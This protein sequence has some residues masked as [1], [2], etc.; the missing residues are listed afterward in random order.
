M[1][2]TNEPM[3]PSTG[4]KDATAASG[5]KP[6][7][8]TK[9]D[10]TLPAKSDMKKVEAHS[11]NDKSSVKQKI[12]V[13]SSIN[14]KRTVINSN[15]TSVCKTYNKCLM[16]VKKP[17]VNKPTRRKFT[18]G[19]QY[20]LTR[21]TESKV[22]PAKQT[23]SVLQI[24]LSYLNSSCSKHMTGDRSRIRNFMK[25]FIR[26]VRFKND[27]FGAIMGYG[28]YVI[29]D[30]VISRVYY[31]EGLGHN[32]FS[33]GQFCDSDLE[34]DETP[35]FVIKFLKQIQVG[36]NKTVR[37]IRT[38]IGTEFVNQV[39]TEYYESVSIFHQKSVPRTPQ[40]IGIIERWNYTLVE[41]ARTML[42]F[43]T[44]L[45]FLWVEAV[46]TACYT[47]NR[48]LIHTRHNKT[49][50]ELV[51]DKKPD[52][53]FLYVFGALCYPT[54]DSEDLG[55][56]RPTAD[57][58]IFIGYA[59]NRKGY[60]IYNKRTQRIM[61][62]IHMQFDKLTEPMAPVH[63]STRPEPILLTPRQ[64]SVERPVPPA[65]AVQV[66]IA[67][68]GT[69]S[70][71]IIDQDAP[72]T[73]YSPSSSV[74]QPPIS[75]QGVAARPTIEDNPFAQ[76]DNDPFVNVFA[77]E[78]SY[79]E[80]SSGD[81][82]SAEST[83]V[84][85]PHNHLRKWSKD[86][87]LDNELVP[88]PGCVMIIALKWIY[89][90]KLDEYGDV[91]KNKAWYHAKPTKKDLEAIKL[92][93]HKEK[94]V[95]KCLVSWR[96]LVSWSSKKQKSTAISTTEVE[97][98]AMSGCYAQILWMR[99]R[100]TDY[101]SEENLPAPTRSDEQLVPV[102]AH[103]PY[104]KSNL[105]LNLQKLQKN[106]IFR[107]YVDILQNTNFFRAFSA[108]A[109][110]PS[111]YI[112]HYDLLCDALEITLVDPANPFVSPPAGEIVM[113]FMNELGYPKVI[114]FVSHMHVNNLFQP[115]REILSLINQ[116][117]T[118]K[119]SR[120]DKPR[121]HVL[122][123]LWGIMTR[124]NVD[125]AELLWEEFV[126][127]IQTFFTHRDS[128]KIPS[129]KPTPHVIPYCRFTKLIIYYLG[130]KYNIHRRP[131]SP[132][133]VTGD[134]FLPGN[135]KFVPKGKKDEVFGMPIPKELITEA[136]Q[137]S[138]YYMQYVEMAARKVEAKEGGKKK[139][140][141][142]A[143]KPVKPAPTKQPKPKPI[144]ENS[145]KPTRVQ[146][147]GKGKV[148]KV[149]K[150]K[151]PLK[152]I[153]EEEHAEREPEPEP[154]GECEE[155][156][157]ERAIQMS[158][159]S[160]EAPGQAH[161][162]GVDIPEPIAE[163]T[164]QLLVVEGKGK[165]IATDEQ[166]AQSLL[167]LHKPKKTIF[168]TSSP[169]NAETDV[170]NKVNLEEKTAEIN[171][172][173][174]GSDP[175]KTPKSRPPTEHVLMEEDKAGPDPGQSH[176]DFARPEPEPMHDDFIATMYPQVHESL[177]L[178]DEEHAQEQDKANM[179]T[180]VESMVTVLVQQASSSVSLLST[181]VIDLTPLKPVSSTIQE[182]VFTT[183]TTTTTTLPLPPPPQ[184]QSITDFLLA[185]R[186]LTLE[187]RSLE[188][189]MEL[190]NRDEFLAEKDKSRKRRHDDKDPPPP[191]PDLDLS[192]KKRHESDASGSKQPLAPQSSAWKTSNTREAPSSSSKQK[193]VHHS[194][195]PAEDVPI[196]DDVNISDSED[197]DTAHLLK[198]KTRPD[199]LKPVPEE[200][201]P[202]T[203]EPD[204]I[205]PPN[206][207]PETENNWA[208]VLT[209]SYQ[210]PDEYKL[211]WQTGD[212][213][214]FINWFCKRI[215]KKKLSKADLEGPTLKV[216]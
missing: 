57:I 215:G 99:S 173:Q 111:I 160:F 179:E 114:H 40:Q 47:Q 141:P 153:N 71:T 29:G 66:P 182:Q 33:V 36:L 116:C 132:R 115:W 55:K 65:P 2:K 3:I 80:S 69:P 41:A 125:Y 51:H 156:D 78:P 172:G 70:S 163:T 126:Q 130:S 193:F 203:P 21:F 12:C 15:C 26:T 25:K 1:K 212:M 139:T 185:Y 85:H 210:D 24:V 68:A 140:A 77:P 13:D 82:S 38:D 9:K 108:S 169:T 166:A 122:Q 131:E 150:G 10:R 118:G 142:K 90:V 147:V 133:H 161:V 67:S 207:L 143:D 19:E 170:E 98:I 39:L 83:Q 4:I 206:D 197:I 76:A 101:M 109:N 187:Q 138:E 199:W 96:Q 20:P 121:H 205:I 45:M 49:P 60:R 95:W 74:I 208:N 211:L 94:Y 146:K 149:L 59:P 113:D 148:Q 16:F 100:L 64:I 86:H 181:P 56:L 42:I 202:E 8:N 58:G 162:G 102:K 194:K 92:S 154:Q 201:R 73:S 7:S 44:A 72:S 81:V 53:K 136:I 117:L 120:N 191:L 63:I 168:D 37:Y 54:N 50:Y 6:R 158:M 91:L 152:L 171:E 75:H 48:S 214:S 107:I 175:G 112:Q 88:K 61:E 159:E 180:K 28:D 17:P 195:Q 145:T 167:D 200:D 213:S 204:W 196:P 190:A 134:D 184:Q 11:R 216:V 164:R 52:L 157:V 23:E 84:I 192:K 31:V 165:A 105:L 189:S 183:T 129:K 174:A 79:D 198:I 178:P 123:M 137:K 62:T 135:L 30:S 93:R 103:L 186:V 22:M 32:L 104:G 119:T 18:L 27:H 46:A 43:S 87:P 188:A 127:G 14:F 177:K 34:K 128:N 209:S 151:S 97:Y 176:V 124:T 144:K 35:E 155:Y 5:S 110:V 106:P 89:K